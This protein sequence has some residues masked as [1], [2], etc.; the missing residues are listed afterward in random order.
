MGKPT[1]RLFTFGLVVLALIQLAS[2]LTFAEGTGDLAGSDEVLVGGS[3]IWIE[4]VNLSVGTVSGIALSLFA[5]FVWR[6]NLRQHRLTYRATIR[7][8]LS[9]A[10]F[11]SATKILRFEILLMTVSDTV[12][13]VTG[14]SAE[15]VCGQYSHGLNDGK[16][17]QTELLRTTNY[18]GGEGWTIAKDIPTAL[19]VTKTIDYDLTEPTKVNAR[20]T[21][22]DG[23]DTETLECR[24]PVK[25][26]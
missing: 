7:E 15:V 26:S 19:S 1:R 21:Y 10:R 14:W 5:F 12:P 6:L 13:V 16:L 24:V 18:I 2:V 9:R 25:V 11:D 3:M 20:I 23:E 17:V 4:Y 8:G 22:T